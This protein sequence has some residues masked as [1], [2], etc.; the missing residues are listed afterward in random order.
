MSKKVIIVGGG[1]SGLS[2]GVY[3][4]KSGF[5]V[6]IHE[7]NLVVGGECTGWDREGFYID[8]CI[9]WLMGTTK[10]TSL[11][12]LWN[13]IG[14]LGEGVEVITSDKMYTSRFDG[15]EATLWK[16]IDRTERELIELSPQ[17]KDEI[18]KLMAFCRKC[19]KIKIPAEKP[20]EQMGL[21]DLFKMMIC[22]GGALKIFKSFEGLDIQDLMNKF[23][24]PVIKCLISDFCP[25]ESKASSFPMAYG[26]FVS[27]DGGVPR[28]GSRALA[29]RIG[30]RFES[31]G[32]KII[33]SSPVEKVVVEK[34]SEKDGVSRA[35]GIVVKGEFIPADYVICSCDTDF[36]FSKLL[37][38][39]YM[40]PLLA[41]MYKDRKAYP[42]Y[43]MFQVAY[44]VDSS[45]DLLK[46]E[47]MM[48]TGDLRFAPWVGERIT[49]KN[50]AYEPSFAPEGKQILQVM[51]GLKEEGWEYWKELY[52][53]KEAYRAKKQE[54]A[55]NI[56]KML[57]EQFPAYCGKLRILDVW[58]PATYHRYCNAYKGYNQAFTLTK[59]SAANPYP[60]GI[61]KGLENV[62]LAG[63]WMS[64]P[65]GLPGAAI[66]GK[67]AAMRVIARA[68]S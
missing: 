14:A 2:A 53:D 59:Y 65:G 11:N 66:Q 7:K 22:Y 57:E 23:H 28:G 48:E 46:G 68:K 60:S 47:I 25:M 49:V 26:N 21:R 24:S 1:I 15:K 17:D 58:T 56:L 31:L 43:G 10:G 45:E 61:I 32:G 12:K 6:E 41:N 13:E 52:K 63:Q 67:Y 62:F 3:L 44:A 30:K 55:E 27:G 16:D 37:D 38:S 34:S 54:I 8:N 42:V 9:H 40:E 64:P 19:I 4:A 35:S 50:F 33:T 51:L 20:T 39:S 29:L 18:L 5:D 36:T